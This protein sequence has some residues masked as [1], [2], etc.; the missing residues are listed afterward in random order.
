[1]R[2]LL[3]AQEGAGSRWEAGASSWDH[4]GL[5]TGTPSSLPSKAQNTESYSQSCPRVRLSLA[6]KLCLVKQLP[7]PCQQEQ[8]GLTQTQGPGPDWVTVFTLF[9]SEGCQSPNLTSSPGSVH[10]SDT[11]VLSQFLLREPRAP[12]AHTETSHLDF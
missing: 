3:T 5:C 4:P 11:T 6:L 12:S 1:M 2:R 10:E 7:S 8:T 9:L